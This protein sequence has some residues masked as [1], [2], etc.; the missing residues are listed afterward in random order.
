MAWTLDQQ[1]AINKRGGKILVSAAAG[2]GKT[3]VLSQRV[4]NYVLNGND[5]DK[6]LIV[7]FTDA[8]SVE[9]R[10]RIKK[11][12]EDEVRK[13]PTDHLKR[14]LI[15]IDNTKITTMDAF[16]NELVKQNFE[17]LG[18]KKEFSI[19]SS[20][21]EELI[22]KKVVNSLYDKKLKDKEFLSLLSF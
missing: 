4:L 10:T 9:M 22:K 14:Q 2:S 6:L 15:L 5:V 18:I 1:R 13:N 21:E 16:Y 17:K 19:L 8:A 20:F 12:I 3:A 11:N 7:T